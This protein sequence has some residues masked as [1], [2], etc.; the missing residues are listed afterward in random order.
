M[1]VRKL[2]AV[3]NGA[4][5]VL[6]LLLAT[7]AVAQNDPVAVTAARLKAFPVAQSIERVDA[8]VP[9]ETVKGRSRPMNAA[10]PTGDLARGIAQGQ[11]Y[12]E[13]DSFAYVVLKDGRIVHEWYA[14]GFTADNRFSPA[15][16][17]KTVMALT[18]GTTRIALDA[19]VDR[20]LTEW[21]GDP[22]GSITVRQ[23]LTMSSGLDVIP[24]SQDPASK[25]MQLQFGPDVTRTA[26]S[27]AAAE[28][29]GTR[30][31]YG[32]VNSQLAALI[33]ERATGQ[34][35]AEVLSRRLWQPIGA[36]DASLWLDREGG[37]AKL[38]CCYQAT[39]RDYARVG[40]LILNRGRANGRQVVPAAW[41]RA[42]ATP[43]ATNPN[44]GLQLWIGSPFVAER[45]YSSVSP[46]VLRSKRPFVRDDV[47]FMDGAVG[48][49]V[50]V[51]PS[52]RLVVVRIGKSRMDW[53][54]TELVNRILA[55]LPEAK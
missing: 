37:T 31:Q 17:A 35:F 30:F 1:P 18:F 9:A 24:F 53:D 23:L 45:R 20:W 33:V 2:I 49:R 34:R 25:G 11:A 21:R 6:L 46:L 14:P 42:M 22:R 5:R 47:L 16:M 12:V 3:V 27:F 54:D 40:Q 43:A 36:S 55:P 32:N 29:P 50:Y 26:L 52:E 41:V 28:A 15:S 4:G 13:R 48:Q 38:W 7:P 19:R 8:Y 39:A 44:F 10:T 51:V